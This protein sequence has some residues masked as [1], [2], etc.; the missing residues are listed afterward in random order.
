MSVAG[1]TMGEAVV[2]GG[3][4]VRSTPVTGLSTPGTTFQAWAFGVTAS[5]GQI[6]WLGE[7]TTGGVTGTGFTIY[8]ER[9]NASN[10]TVYWVHVGY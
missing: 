1:M 6:A 9:T 3:A 5:P 10:I 8:L 2:L 7:I 4:G